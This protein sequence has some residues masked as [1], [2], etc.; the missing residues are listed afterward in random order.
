LSSCASLNG[1][2][3]PSLQIVR[4]KNYNVFTYEDAQEDMN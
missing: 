4:Q 1:I 2:R 3:L